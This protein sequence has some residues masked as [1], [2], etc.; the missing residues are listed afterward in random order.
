MISSEYNIE[1]VCVTLGDRGAILFKN[2]IIDYCKN[3]VENVI[4]T[5]GAGDAYSSI[6]CLGYLYEW[7]I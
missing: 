6:L 3:Q 1:L 5:V 7:D 2:G 4:D